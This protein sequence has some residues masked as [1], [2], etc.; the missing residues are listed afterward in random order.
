MEL[1]WCDDVVLVVFVV[2]GGGCFVLVIDDYKDIDVLYMELCGGEV[3]VN[4]D[5]CSE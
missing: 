4:D 5:V 1:V 2:V 3:I